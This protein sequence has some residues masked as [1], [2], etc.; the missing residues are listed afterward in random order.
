MCP[1]VSTTTKAKAARLSIKDIVPDD[2]ITESVKK[3][4]STSVVKTG[5]GA[6]PGS[7]NNNPVGAN[8]DEYMCPSITAQD[9]KRLSMRDP[10]D[11]DTD[12]MVREVSSEYLDANIRLNPHVSE[13]EHVVFKAGRGSRNYKRKSQVADK[14]SSPSILDL[15][16][17]PLSACVTVPTMPPCRKTESDRGNRSSRGRQISSTIETDIS[18]HKSAVD[19]LAAAFEITAIQADDA[20][21]SHSAT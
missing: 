17:P 6:S 1:A 3:K 11:S 9:D 19:D 10:T 8:K 16:S 7:L 5:D 18:K 20:R 14:S 4:P 13:N 2:L 21:K 12:S 15:E